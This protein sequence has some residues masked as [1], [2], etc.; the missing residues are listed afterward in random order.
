MECFD[1]SGTLFRWF[2]ACPSEYLWL[3][4]RNERKRK[5][6]ELTHGHEELLFASK[7]NGGLARNF[8]AH[9]ALCRSVMWQTTTIT[10]RSIQC[11]EEQR[12]SHFMHSTI[13]TGRTCDRRHRCRISLHVSH[14]H[15][16]SLPFCQFLF[17]LFALTMNKRLAVTTFTLFTFLFMRKQ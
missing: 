9:V 6:K 5:S 1:P 13:C 4:E 17:K 11:N 15:R 2:A 16:S 3:R 12:P 14:V 8:L 7:A 10:F